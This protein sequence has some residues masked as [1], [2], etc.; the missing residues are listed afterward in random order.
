MT[1]KEWIVAVRREIRAERGAHNSINSAVAE[2]MADL[3]PGWEESVTKDGISCRVVV[4]DLLEV[5]HR[6][7]ELHD[8]LKAQLPGVLDEIV[9]A[10]GGATSGIDSE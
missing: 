6:L 2:A 9:H 7:R 5:A 4:H 8:E 1:P 3:F 10:S